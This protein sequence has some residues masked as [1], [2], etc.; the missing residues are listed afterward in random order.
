[1]TTA[2]GSARSANEVL[3]SIG[4]L[5]GFVRLAAR[6]VPFALPYWD[7]L[8]L[9]IILQGTDSVM[10]VF[11]AI[12]AGRVIDSLVASDRAGFLK[13]AT[14]SLLMILGTL[15]FLLCWN[16]LTQHVMLHLNLRLKRRIFEHVQR[17][18]L[19]FHESRPIGENMYR[20]NNDTTFATDLTCNA[21]PEIFERMI[22]ILMTVT[23]MLSL[24]PLIGTIISIYIVVHFLFSHYIMG[25]GYR[26]QV[27]L[28]LRQQNVSAILQESLSAYAISKAMSRERHEMR[29]YYG[30][31]V[32]FLRA[33]LRFYVTESTW[34]QGTI[35]LHELVRQPLLILLCGYYILQG[36]M[37]VGD[38]FALQGLTWVV[39]TPLILFVHTIQR[40]RLATV[41]A[42]RMLQTL[43]VEPEIQDKP[44][45]VKLHAPKGR[46]DFVHVYYRYRAEGPDVV[47]DLSFTVRP[48]KKLAIVGVSGAGKTSIFNLLM[49][50]ADPTQGRV[51]ID[52]L[53][54]TCIC[55]QSYLNNVSIVLQDNFLFSTTLRENIL[56][57]NIHATEEQLHAAVERSGL[58]PVVESLPNGLDTLMLEGGNLS[59]GE[60]Q[61]VAI[62]RA[63]VRN[64]KF[65]YLDEA[66]SSLDP[67]TESRT[68]DQ[69][70]KMESGRTRIVIAH[71]ITSIQ[72]ADEILVMDH[73][74]CVQR[75]RHEDLLA[76][77]GAYRQLWSAEQV[78]TKGTVPNYD[79]ASDSPS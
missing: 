59:T 68:L 49:R 71:S 55:K 14:L 69:L 31:L 50:F 51:L 79:T 47:K 37:T 17:M 30:R 77:E 44:N 29:R 35:I 15:I 58:K 18:S 62:A 57:G 32:R 72:D 74:V 23:V 48:G 26:F 67:V 22:P 9:R 66:T 13:W 40:L 8:L 4:G 10:R 52:G 56:V 41:P 11:A 1:M 46:I 75:G 54:L 70:K 42:Q 64:P 12:A 25:F 6:F 27:Q 61:N 16:L 38:Y 5:R 45:A 33:W 3:P 28:R 21:L 19:A 63:V 65:L 24:N 78:K 20:I 76:M 39:M 60:K 73:G 43:D 53:D 36:T 2:E 7:K 34:T